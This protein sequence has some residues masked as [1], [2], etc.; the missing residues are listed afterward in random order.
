MIIGQPKLEIDTPALWVDLEV[1]ER[2]IQQL[3]EFFRQ[4][5]VGW[6][7]HIKGIKVP[8]IAH[9]LVDAGALGITCAKLGEAEVMAA[10]GIKDILIANQIVGQTK[11]ARLV[12]LRRHA[13][14]VVAVDCV[15]N[16]RELSQA[17]ESNGVQLRVLIELNV[18]MNRCGVM[19]GDEVNR[20]AAQ[21]AAL[22]G[23][24]LVGLMGWEGHA[25]AVSDA[26]EKARLVHTAVGAL[27]ESAELCRAAGFNI[28]IVSCGGSG[29]YRITARMPGVT[30]IE[31]GGAVFGDVA[32]RRWG[33]Q[34]ECSLFVLASVVSRPSPTRA[35]VD[36]GRKAMNGDV[37]MPECRDL[38]GVRL[39][40]LHAEHGL[41]E[42]D[43]PDV[44]LRVGDKI[45][46]VVGY[47]DNTVFLHDNL[48]GLRHGQ[49]E[50][51]WDIL[52]RGK[53]A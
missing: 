2:N 46:F 39:S 36:A 41:L 31:A 52:A 16:A 28:A 51:V 43:R 30:E 17:A 14:V 18:G 50:V 26:D 47:G 38:A 42:L 3:A 29:T 27:V 45:D 33:A 6:R 25:V 44:P 24:R 12:A 15:E 32:Y 20:L 23:I 53:L 10:A 40:S 1:M 13:D 4:A 48:Y 22:R 8:A 35:I 19:P 7:P 21:L 5:G 11:I 9:M 37:A 49:V 34:T